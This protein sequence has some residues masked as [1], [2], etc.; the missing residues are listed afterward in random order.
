MRRGLLVVFLLVVSLT[1]SKAKSFDH[2][3]GGAPE[4][5]RTVSKTA[6]GSSFGDSEYAGEP[7]SLDLVNQPLSEVLRF[8]AERY[9][10]N[11]VFDKSVEKTIVTIQC[12]MTPWNEAVE[13][14]LRANG[15]GFR[16]EKSFVRIASLSALT[17]EAEE[18]RKQRQAETLNQERKTVFFK[19]RYAQV[20]GGGAEGA[21][22]NRPEGGGG[23]VSGDRAAA[24]I[25]QA[26]TGSGLVAIVTQNLSPVGSVAV[27][28]RTNTLIVTDGEKQIARI[29][30]ILDTLDAPEPQIQIEARIVVAN[31]NFTRDLGALVNA[32][33]TSGR[34]TAA[35]FG[36]GAAS[37]GSPNFIGPT[38]NN[39]LSGPPASV[40]NF[41]N[42]VG[43][44]RI[45]AA[46]TAQEERGVVQTLSAPHVIVQN[47]Q[48]AEV[49]RGSL[50][51]F[52][53]AQGL[54]ATA[55]TTTTFQNANLG[56]TVTPRVASDSEILLELLVN[57]D[58]IDRTIAINGQPPIS[59]QSVATRVL[60]PNG[61]AVMLSGVISDDQ[62]QRLV[63]TPGLA[64]IPGIGNF[65]KRQVKNRS[66]SE[67]LFFI[68]AR[69]VPVERPVEIITRPP[70][71]VIPNPS[72]SGAPLPPL[73][74]GDATRGQRFERLQPTVGSKTQSRQV[75]LSDQIL[76]EEG[77]KDS[78]TPTKAGQF[79]PAAPSGSPGV[80]SKPL[81][82]QS[83][84]VILTDELLRQ[85]REGKAG[86]VPAAA[87]SGS[88]GV[89]SKPLPLQSSRVILTDE[90]LRQSRE[91]KA[92]DVPVAASSGSPGVAS[93]LPSRSAVKNAPSQVSVASPGVGSKRLVRQ[94]SPRRSLFAKAKRSAGLRSVRWRPKPHA[95]EAWRLRFALCTRVSSPK[96]NR[97]ARLV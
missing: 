40:L 81:P 12:R 31:R 19:L 92:G 49:L 77:K 23:E 58:S 14:M 57:N 46:L 27:D 10:A 43:T 20:G 41:F 18:L 62:L 3:E 4:N 29:Q 56:L 15:L 93:G 84:R 7:V 2:Q 97:F 21:A 34:G 47:N 36:T 6:S 60:C 32:G 96:F 51:P 70:S 26:G 80:A 11:F 79:P 24:P 35:Q 13:A 55:V 25:G 9:Q 66:Q 67:L 94:S 88:P 30:K 53:S 90:L 85:S 54:G 75:T 95:R 73:D 65:F 59:K 87:S 71:L 83:S 8:F 76:Q 63:Q 17:T 33:F 48:K 39:A 28:P 37:G 52:T 86:D 45:A 5:G 82:P 42:P 91:G 69:I 44:A 72:D 64:K 74:G 16:K 50:I 61:G 89:A 68:T 78:G 22:R 38:I 1:Q